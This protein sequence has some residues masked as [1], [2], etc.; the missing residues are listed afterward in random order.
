MTWSSWLALISLSWTASSIGSRTRT[1]SQ[2]GRPPTT[3]T[4]AVTLPLS[5]IST[6]NWSATSTFS[7]LRKTRVARHLFAKSFLTSCEDHNFGVLTPCHFNVSEGHSCRGILTVRWL[8]KE[9]AHISYVWGPPS[10]AVA[11]LETQL[12]LKIAKMQFWNTCISYVDSVVFLCFL[13][14]S[15]IPHLSPHPIY[16]Y[17]FDSFL[18][19]KLSNLKTHFF[20]CAS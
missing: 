1:W 3:A 7:M 14:G 8:I 12:G 13:I 10:A 15:G 2:S 9:A 18:K 16:K 5:W 6:T 19:W 11:I 17:I 20:S 4:V